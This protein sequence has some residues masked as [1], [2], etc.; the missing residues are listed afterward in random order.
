MG[1]VLKKSPWNV[2]KSHLNLLKYDDSIPLKDWQFTH[3]EW[4]VQFKNL[5]LEHHS[6]QVIYEA[7]VELGS[8]ISTNPPNYRPTFGRLISARVKIDLRKPLFR[9]GWWN[10]RAGGV[11]WV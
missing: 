1:V 8:K 3:Q 5:L 6:V 10:T 4:T 9:G 11:T 2:R 7:L